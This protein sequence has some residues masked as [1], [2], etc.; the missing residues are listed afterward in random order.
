MEA[1]RLSSDKNIY[2]YD[3]YYYMAI[4]GVGW[5]GTTSIVDVHKNGDYYYVAYDSEVY[6][7]THPER[8]YAMLRLKEIDGKKY[9]SLYK[10]SSNKLD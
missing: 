7:I 6:P 4:F 9:W 8:R 1:D 5:E 3:G 2:L 10:H